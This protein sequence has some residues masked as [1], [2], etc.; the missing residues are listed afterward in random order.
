MSTVQK[1]VLDLEKEKV[2]RLLKIIEIT[3]ENAIFTKTEGGFLSLEFEGEKYDRVNFHRTFPFTS[4][5]DFI[6]VRKA[7]DKAE[8]IGIIV[9]LD[10]FDSKTK[11][12]ILHQLELRYFMPKITKIISI[13]EEYGSCYWAVETNKGSCKFSMNAHGSN[14]IKLSETHL[15]IKDVDGNRYEIINTEALTPK[16]LKKLDLYI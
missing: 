5:N 16:E 13:K 2:D 10:V 15:I 6:S 11:E 3:S 9:S 7:Q 8:E 14:T 4:T 1:D 12:D